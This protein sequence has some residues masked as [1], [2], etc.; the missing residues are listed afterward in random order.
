M[1]TTVFCMTTRSADSAPGDSYRKLGKVKVALSPELSH[2]APQD[3]SLIQ[4]TRHSSVI[5]AQLDDASY[6]EE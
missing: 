2:T 4:V 3:E 5:L 1:S 6:M